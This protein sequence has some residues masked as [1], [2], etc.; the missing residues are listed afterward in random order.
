VIGLIA[1]LTDSPRRTAPV[2]PNFRS[3][4]LELPKPVEVKPIEFPLF[5]PLQPSAAPVAKPQPKHVTSTSGKTKTE[6]LVPVKAHTGF[7]KHPSGSRIAPLTI[8]TEAGANYYVRLIDA[9]SKNMGRRSILLVARPSRNMSPSGDYRIRYA[10]GSPWYGE[11]LRF[12]P[13][14]H[15]V[16]ANETFDFWKRGN[17][18]RGYKI[19]LIMQVGGNLATYPISEKDF[20]N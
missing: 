8:K 14:T 17:Q 7:L 12:G 15:Y 5:V 16:E 2:A 11:R 6:G 19:E 10:S 13:D 4:L 1:A 18:V 20:D 3:P 9:S